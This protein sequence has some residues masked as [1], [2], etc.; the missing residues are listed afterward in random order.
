MVAGEAPMLLAA[1]SGRAYHSPEGK[2]EC[3]T[4]GERREVVVKW[5][6]QQRLRV[7]MC[8]WVAGGAPAADIAV[9]DTCSDEETTMMMGEE[10]GGGA[11]P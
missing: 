10:R 8:G 6:F 2:G 1:P 7:P 5:F 11:R 9:A 3:I 4:L